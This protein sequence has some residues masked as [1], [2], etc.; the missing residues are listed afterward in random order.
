VVNILCKYELERKT[1]N[2]VGFDFY[3]YFRYDCKVIIG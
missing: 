1:I 3:I 2:N